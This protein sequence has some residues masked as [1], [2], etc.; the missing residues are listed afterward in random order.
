MS[1]TKGHLAQLY[2]DGK[3]REVKGYQLLRHARSRATLYM[4][5]GERYYPGRYGVKIFEVDF[6]ALTLT[7]VDERGKVVPDEPTPGQD[8]LF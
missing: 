1:A 3:P 2:Y 8:T 5:E 7:Q 4:K 6:D